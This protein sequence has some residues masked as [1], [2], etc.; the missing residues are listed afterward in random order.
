MSYGSISNLSQASSSAKE[1]DKDME[2]VAIRKYATFWKRKI[3]TVTAKLVNKTPLGIEG[4]YKYDENRFKLDNLLEDMN[5][6]DTDNYHMR[7]KLRAHYHLLPCFRSCCCGKDSKLKDYEIKAS[8]WFLE[9]P[10]IFLTLEF[11][12]FIS[13]I[14]ELI[15]M[16]YKSITLYNH[17]ILTPVKKA[18]IL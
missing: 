10:L 9:F 16:I 6:K 3:G 11:W 17:I 15:F 14:Y 7:E 12:F 4:W 1:Y 8:Y 2:E 18:Y 13:T 5:V